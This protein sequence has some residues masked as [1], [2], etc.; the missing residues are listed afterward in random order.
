METMEDQTQIVIHLA[1]LRVHHVE[2]DYT[3]PHVL[4]HCVSLC[5][6]VETRVQRQLILEDGKVI[7]DTGPQVTTKTTE[8][9]RTEE[10][11]NRTLQHKRSLDPGVVSEKTETH[12]VSKEVKEENMRL[13]DESFQDMSPSVSIPFLSVVRE[14]YHE[15][16]V[17][18]TQEDGLFVP[19][20]RR[21]PRLTH[22]SSRGQKVV[23]R[24]EVQ[25]VQEVVGGELTTR[26]HRTHQHMEQHDDEVPQ[27]EDADPVFPEMSSESSRSIEYP[28]S[29]WEYN[30]LAG[31]MRRE[32]DQVLERH[33]PG[34]TSAGG[35]L[36][37]IQMN[38]PSP[39]SRPPSVASQRPPSAASHRPPSAASHRP[40]SAN[41]SATPSRR[42]YYGDET[43][44]HSVPR[45]P[46]RP[47]PPRAPPSPPSWK[48]LHSPPSFSPLSSPSQIK[49][50]S[51]SP[52]SSRN[53]TVV[54]PIRQN[55]YRY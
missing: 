8:D 31:Q 51:S 39:R 17:L 11:E 47:S 42:F 37:R 29:D 54:I 46:T 33:F 18:A 27:A 52:S 41:G 35:N 23:D 43:D 20:Q 22:Y 2:A 5:R 40:P 28:R 48:P 12:Q 7:A 4:R 1:L 36:I 14:D 38:S 50:M 6:Q 21:E 49:H 13:H 15:R 45:S 24:E 30:Q 3:T 10:S 16:A 25:E 9:N 26:T 53:G 44:R 32:R 19:V 34:E 55:S